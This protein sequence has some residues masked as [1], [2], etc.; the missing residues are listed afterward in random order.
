MNDRA[1]ARAFGAVLREVRSARGLTQEDL[2]AEAE[3]DRTYPSL[4]ERGHRLPTLGVYF[5]LCRAL[6]CAPAELMAATVDGLSRF[7]IPAALTRD[8]IP[9]VITHSADNGALQ[10]LAAELQEH[11]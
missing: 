7:G 4:L 11:R 2:A 1:V 3:V 6:R 9:L 8:A 10:A 5:R